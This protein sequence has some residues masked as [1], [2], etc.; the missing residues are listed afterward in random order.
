MIYL[1]KQK[2][3]DSSNFPNG[4]NFIYRM[5]GFGAISLTS[6]ILLLLCVVSGIG[7]FFLIGFFAFVF[8]LLPSLYLLLQP[9][10]RKVLQI[11]SSKRT[12]FADIIPAVNFKGDWLM[13]LD[14]ERIRMK[15]LKE[16]FKF[17]WEKKI[18]FFLIAPGFNLALFHV[19]YLLGYFQVDPDVG[20]NASLR[21]NDLLIYNVITPFIFILYFTIAWVW[22]SAEIKIAKI[23]TDSAIHRRSQQ[24]EEYEINELG[25]ASNSFQNIILFFAGI[26]AINWAVSVDTQYGATNSSLL[27]SF[28]VNFILFVVMTIGYSI[29]IGVMYFRSSAHEKMVNNLRRNIWEDYSKSLVN[30]HYK[31]KYNINIMR[32]SI[33]DAKLEHLDKQGGMQ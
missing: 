28:L 27:A 17:I 6:I 13:E 21:E 26:N 10:I 14:S 4:D 8:V 12:D 5:Y 9:I 3:Y 29:F 33:P 18:D 11:A 23:N 31:R 24:G 30:P 25:F 16:T 15:N 22:E 20:L 32:T 19:L 2:N 7:I 1:A